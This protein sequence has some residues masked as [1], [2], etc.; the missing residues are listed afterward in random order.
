MLHNR[1]RL[2]HEEQAERSFLF[3]LELLNVE[4]KL[5][6]FEN[7]AIETTRLSGT[8]ADASKQVVGVELVSDVLL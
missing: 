4:L 7:V 1:Q 6:A 5:L 3:L 8:G 2:R